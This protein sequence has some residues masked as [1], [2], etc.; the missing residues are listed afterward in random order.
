M[1][2][3]KVVE[4]ILPTFGNNIETWILCSRLAAPKR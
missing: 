2:N 3:R 1:Q 4:E